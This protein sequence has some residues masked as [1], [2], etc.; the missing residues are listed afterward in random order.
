MVKD[1]LPIDNEDFQRLE[2]KVDRLASIMEDV[3]EKLS[4]TTIIAK[5]RIIPDAEAKEIEENTFQEH[6][7]RER[8]ARTHKRELRHKFNLLLPPSTERVLN[9][10]TTNDPKVFDGLKRNGEQDPNYGKGNRGK[11]NKN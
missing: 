5:Q 6:L 2:T 1:H 7:N 3:L 4:S 10:L 11:R 9:Y 8:F